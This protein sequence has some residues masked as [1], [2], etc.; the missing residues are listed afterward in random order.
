MERI[1][2]IRKDDRGAVMVIGV[3]MSA[4]LV[5]CLWYIIGLGDAVVYR[6]Y[7]QDG[8]DAT[9]Y[10]AAVYQ[11]RGMN[12]IALMN[13]IMAAVLAVLV[14]LKIAQVLITIAMAIACLLSWTGVGAVACGVLKGA[15]SAVKGLIATV[16]PIVH[17]VL[18]G[19]YIA[20]SAVAVGMPFVAEFKAISVA[21]SYGPTVDGGFMVSISLI[22]GHLTKFLGDIGSKKDEPEAEQP[23]E[24]SKVQ[25]TDDWV[26][27]CSCDRAN[28]SGCCSHHGGLSNPRRC[29]V[30]EQPEPANEEAEPQGQ[31]NP[32]E[33]VRWGLPVEDDSFPFLC[34]KAGE[35]VV[36]LIF[37]PLGEAGEWISKFAGGMV[38]TLTESFPGYFCGAGG[39]N[40]SGLTDA[41][42]EAG[43]SVADEE[44]AGKTEE[45]EPGEYDPEKCK[46]ELGQVA[47]GAGAESTGAGLMVPKKVYSDAENGD[48]Y[49]AS[50]SFVWGDLKQNSDA[51]KGVDIAAWNKAKVGDPSFLSSYHFAKSEYYY[52]PD[53]DD[54][55]TWDGL[56]EDAMWNMRW[57]A[58]LR[59]TYLPPLNLGAKLAEKFN[60][61]VGGE[62]GGLLGEDSV[63]TE[64]VMEII[65][66]PVEQLGE[67]LDDTIGE[68]VGN[69]NQG[70]IH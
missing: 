26:S 67:Q 52:E 16:T 14:A 24:V 8:A 13:L 50:W 42:C 34:G 41:A 38:K 57:R 31:E 29:K 22:P 37:L 39:V 2:N 43:Q 5:G 4:F 36:D 25:C 9:A 46:E 49:F 64:K 11:A 56:V 59:R 68:Q 62:I 18:K 12:I 63:L 69:I 27:S 20:E 55:K 17:T 15:D 44:N 54:P 19:L 35:M 60:E 7:M 3:F 48:N 10:A 53:E 40:I 32:N 28:K 21:K 6:Q 61:Y 70:I 1:S 66:N 58:R 65:S 23:E 45:E 51:A 33:G 30:V 47:E